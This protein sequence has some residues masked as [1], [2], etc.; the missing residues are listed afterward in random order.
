VNAR[1]ESKLI[2]FEE[3]R[4]RLK[5]DLESE[6]EDTLKKAMEARLRKNAKIEEL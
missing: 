1:E 5:K 3:V 2:S 6:K 4:G